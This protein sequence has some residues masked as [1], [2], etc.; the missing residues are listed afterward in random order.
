MFLHTQQEQEK[1]FEL[2]N[3][4]Q[5]VENENIFSQNAIWSAI[6]NFTYAP[7]DEITFVSYF[8]RCKDLYNTD[9][10]NWADF[11]KVRLL[12]IKLGAVEHTKFIYCPKKTSD[13]TFSEAVQLLTEL[14]SPQKVFIKD[15][16]AWIPQGKTTDYTFA[17]V[18]IKHC[19][20]FKLL[21]S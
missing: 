20:D 18:V 15:G 8:R 13:L 1:L 19:D 5:K 4:V 17:S 21:E 2:S 11:K 9:C 12:L 16:N 3:G 7:R 14:F 10:R 6:D